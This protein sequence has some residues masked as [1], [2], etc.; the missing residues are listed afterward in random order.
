[1]RFISEGGAIEH[2][3]TSLPDLIAA[4]LTTLPRDPLRVCHSR[5]RLT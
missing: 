2:A 3:A 4:R 5:M 1:V